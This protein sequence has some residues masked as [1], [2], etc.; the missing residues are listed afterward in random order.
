MWHASIKTFA[1]D[2]ALARTMAYAALEGR[3]DAS[4]GEWTEPGVA[5]HL[6]RRLSADEVRLA[7]NITVRDIRGTAEER[8]R[9]ALLF[10]D[11]PH[12]RRL[13]R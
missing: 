12:L 5:F 11:A 8:K 9:F 6:R 3:G 1:G 2:M 7:G 10:H 4:L 13:F